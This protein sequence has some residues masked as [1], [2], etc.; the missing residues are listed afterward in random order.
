MDYTHALV[1]DTV[2]TEYRFYSP[3]VAAA[4]RDTALARETRK[5]ALAAEEA[6][7]DCYGRGCSE[8]TFG[9]GHWDQNEKGRTMKN[10]V[11]LYFGGIVGCLFRRGWSRGNGDGDVPKGQ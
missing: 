9:G 6:R 2:H 1:C 8:S 7:K 5:A 11:F 10:D 3:A 4:A